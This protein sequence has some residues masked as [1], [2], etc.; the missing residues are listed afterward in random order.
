MAATGARRALR[1]GSGGL[2]EAARRYARRE[3]QPLHRA[4]ALSCM[5][6][7][8]VSRILLYC[9]LIVAGKARGGNATRMRDILRSNIDH[10]TR[11]QTRI[12][13]GALTHEGSAWPA[14]FKRK[15]RW[16]A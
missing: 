14:N 16:G 1:S 4:N 5:R 7:A 6:M 15:W 10:S 12:T 3:A 13:F 8:L 11:H 2:P 9:C